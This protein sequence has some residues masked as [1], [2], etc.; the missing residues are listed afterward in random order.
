VLFSMTGYGEASLENES[1]RVG[2]RIKSVNNRGLDIH[3]KLP[4]DFMYLE[5]DLRALVQQKLHRGRIDIFSEIEIQDPQLMP[6]V[7]LNKVRMSQL[8]S[9]SQQLQAAYSVEGQLDI[10][11]LIRLPDITQNQRVGFRLPESLDAHILEVFDQALEALLASRQREGEALRP[12]F[13]GTFEGLTGILQDLENAVANRSEALKSAILKRIQL[14]SPD[15]SLDPQRLTQE[16]LYYA[17]RLDITEEI[18]RLKT[19]IQASV[20]LLSS[21]KRP[22]GKEFEFLVQEQFREVTTIGNK[23]KH[24]DIAEQVVRLKTDYEQ[25]REQILN[26]E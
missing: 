8:A 20:D 26:V 4:F 19:H 17:D 7:C 12:F 25:I 11:T 16:V 1:I 18:T 14:L 5:S 15:I 23:A 9:L 2:F 10:N 6:P 13:V 24:Q 21:G 22:L 3:L